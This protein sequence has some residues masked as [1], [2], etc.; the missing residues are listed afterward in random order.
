MKH[1]SE[2]DTFHTD[3]ASL[4]YKRF[5]ID[6]AQQ[7][8]VQV[9]KPHTKGHHHSFTAIRMKTILTVSEL[10]PWFFEDWENF[11]VKDLK[12]HWEREKVKYE[13]DSEQNYQTVYIFDWQPMLEVH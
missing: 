5:R 9:H 12:W 7:N 8:C 2:Q 1:C 10:L 3:L 11:D 13:S 4:L 6:W